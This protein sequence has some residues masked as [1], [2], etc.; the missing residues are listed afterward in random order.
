MNSGEPEAKSA[1][2]SNLEMLGLLASRI[3]HD[4]KNKLAVISGHAQFAEM[5]KGNPK[6]MADAIAIIKRVSEEAG[7]HVETMAKLRRTM[8]VEVRACPMAEAVAMIQEAVKKAGWR[9]T[10]PAQ[11]ASEPASIQPRWLAFMIGYFLKATRAETGTVEMDEALGEVPLENTEVAPLFPDRRHLR[12]R[13]RQ[14]AEAAAVQDP[15]LQFR[16]LAVIELVRRIEG[17]LVQ[18]TGPDGIQQTTV[19]IPLGPKPSSGK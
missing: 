1:E 9:F 12:L 4:L 6:N 16:Q 11:L 2:L 10:P 5:T 8:S 14:Q 13:I 3:I 19:L 18:Q 7:K 17:G 15:A